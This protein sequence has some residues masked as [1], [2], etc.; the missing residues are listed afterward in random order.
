MTSQIPDDAKWR[1]EKA[2]GFLDLRMQGRAL[3]ELMLVSESVQ[4]TTPWRILRLRLA[5]D[6]HD[7]T[8]GAEIAKQ[9]RE[10]QP[11]IV[12]Y[13][14]QLAYA[15]RRCLGIDAAKTILEEAAQRFP[16]IALIPFNLACY[17][18]RLGQNGIAMRHLRRAFE[19][20]PEYRETALEDEDL[21]PLWPELGD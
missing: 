17:E 19:L 5:F 16:E 10:E 3:A 4:R 11:A 2:E 18:C 6:Q 14:I 12:D 20:E 21:K 15:T 13:W 9:L 8:L 7:W 1:M